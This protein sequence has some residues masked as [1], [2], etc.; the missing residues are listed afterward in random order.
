MVEV[1]V[2]VTGADVEVVTVLV[3]ALM[4]VV[5]PVEVVGDFVVVTVFVCEDVLLV[6]VLL[7]LVLLVLVLALVVLVLVVLVEV[8]AFASW[9][10]ADEVVRDFDCDGVARAAVLVRVM[11]PLRLLLRLDAAPDPHAA[12][13]TA[14]VAAR[15]A[16]NVQRLRGK[17]DPGT[18]AEDCAGAHPRIVRSG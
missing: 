1:V 9:E 15:A 12:Q 6:L 13:R 10:V 18:T 2:V 14:Q 5:V 3:C 11:L 7:V 8:A 16:L 4:T 17:V